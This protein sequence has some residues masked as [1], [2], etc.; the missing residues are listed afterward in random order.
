MPKKTDFLR[1]PAYEACCPFEWKFTIFA[2]SFAMTMRSTA[3]RASLRMANVS[4][5]TSNIAPNTGANQTYGGALA[6]VTTLL[7]WEIHEPRELPESDSD[8]QFSWHCC[9]PVDGAIWRLRLHSHFLVSGQSCRP[10]QSG[11]QSG[12]DASRDELEARHSV[13]TYPGDDLLSRHF[14]LYCQRIETEQRMVRH[15]IAATGQLC[16]D[17]RDRDELSS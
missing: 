17:V 14:V 15:R 3:H 16:H 1:F 5:K 8:Y 9:V 11:L 7:Y 6:I 10:D 12:N 4:V 2:A 13:R